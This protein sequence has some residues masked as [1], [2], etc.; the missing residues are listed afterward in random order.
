MGGADSTNS[1]TERLVFSK[2]R[3]RAVQPNVAARDRHD[4][5]RFIRAAKHDSLDQIDLD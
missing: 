2:Y 3:L 1:K 5:A 4:A